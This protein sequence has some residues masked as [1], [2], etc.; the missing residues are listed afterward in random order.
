MNFDAATQS[1]AARVGNISGWA[2]AFLTAEQARAPVPGDA[3]LLVSHADYFARIDVALPGDLSGGRFS[4]VVEAMTDAHYKTA[5]AAT[6]AE[7]YLFW[8]DVNADIGSY[9]VDL[10]GM[11]RAGTRAQLAPALVARFAIRRRS[12]GLGLR[13]GDA[14]FEGRDWAYDRL[15]TT[16]APQQCFDGLGGLLRGIGRAADVTI[17]AEPTES[18]LL[19]P[20]SGPEA[21]QADAAGAGRTCLVVVQNLAERVASGLREDA[22]SVVLLRDGAVH[23][24]RR[25]L[26]F[27]AG[28]EAATL[29]L[30]SGLA[31][32]VAENDGNDHA[33]AR[34]W[35][36]VLRGRP[37]LRPGGLVRFRAP[38]EEVRD[39]LPSAGLAL[40]GVLSGIAAGFGA[41]EPPNTSAYI[42]SV[43][44]RLSRTA[45]FQTEVTAMELP[46]SLPL[47]PWMAFARREEEGPA[48]PVRG[49]DGASLVAR[50]VRDLS[51]AALGSLRLPEVAELRATTPTNPAMPL[52]TV[53]VWE[54]TMGNAGEANTMRRHAIARNRPV[55]RRAVASLTPFAWGA[56]GLALPRYPGMRVAIGFRNGNP[57]DPFEMG[58]TW[59]PG[60]RMEPQPG[61]W[62]L[63]LPRNAST[64]ALAPSD[65]QNHEPG[66]ETPATHD[67]TDAAGNRV[68]QVGKLTLRIGPDENAKAGTRPE[69]ATAAFCLRH[70]DGQA[71]I[72]MDQNGV[73]IIKG[74]A[75]TL[76]AGATGTVEIKAKDVN[77]VV[78]QRV[79][80]T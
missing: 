39:T 46:S 69:V 79:S 55:E 41:P 9:F 62:W 73:I 71:E 59:G 16:P 35:K 49:G 60:T 42:I 14:L 6:A 30:S 13:G 54:G 21:E 2:L 29:D 36:L 50:Q 72:T 33:A 80:V 48:R 38:E 34:S 23:L 44:H 45:G 53:T 37:D 19:P 76:D 28:T 56:C 31:G 78:Q 7:L 24:G 40:G 64:A 1:R 10:L 32:A 8:Q 47:N 43:S 66:T 63:C 70:A 77:I 18:Q 74:K 57:A 58:A 27:P 11:R 52:Q 26:P 65:T 4:V 61:D 25:G 75:I 15:A 5:R 51:R 68:I 67:L 12:R 17:T 3:A 20:G 22:P